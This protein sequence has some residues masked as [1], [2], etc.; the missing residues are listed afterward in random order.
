MDPTGVDVLVVAGDLTMVAYLEPVLTGLCEKYPQVVFVTGNHE[1]Y[2]S[3]REVVHGVLELLCDRLPNLHWLNDTAAVIDGQRFVGC[4]LWFPFI[5][6][7]RDAVYSNFMSDFKVIKDLEDWVYITN[8]ASRLFLET[9]VQSTDVVV[10]HH[11]PHI[12]SYHPRWLNP[13]LNH[14][15]RFFLC[16]MA[17]LIDRVQP[18]LWLHGHTH[19]AVD[20]HVGAT[21]IVCNPHGYPHE[22]YLGYQDRLLIDL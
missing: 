5:G 8:E 14:L 4:A 3:A 9:T 6:D 2:R 16:D 7:G 15:N 22:P 19:D 21:R 17:P 18:K 12:A 1:Y 11:L 13:P 10:T 20:V